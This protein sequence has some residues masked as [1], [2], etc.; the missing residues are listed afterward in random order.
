ME[1]GTAQVDI[2]ASPPRPDPSEP[3]V[4]AEQT[5]RPPRLAN[6][7]ALLRREN[8]DF[9]NVVGNVD[10]LRVEAKYVGGS[11]DSKTFGM[12]GDGCFVIM[13]LSDNP[14]GVGDGFFDL[15]PMSGEGS[16]GH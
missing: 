12:G 14:E 2:S 15:A 16:G 1:N 6:L 4:G 10:S 7:R 11:Q 9:V 13:H 3:R 8:V 5:P